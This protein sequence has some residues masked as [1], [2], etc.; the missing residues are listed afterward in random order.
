[1]NPQKSAL[2]M[3]EFQQEWLDPSV[4]KLDK[5][6]QDRAQFSA[7]QRSAKA[8]LEAARSRAV[9]VIHVP[10]LFQ[11]GYPEI[12]GGLRGGLFRAIPQAGTWIGEGRP[13]APGFEPFEGEF[14]VEGRV[15]A[16]AFA[17]SNLELYLRAQGVT[18]L[19]LC[20][21][22]LHVCVESTLRHGHVLGFDV[23]VLEDA[24]S[25]FTPEQ[26]KHVL[27]EVIHHYGHAVNVETFEHSLEGTALI[28]H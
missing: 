24:C 4:G 21:Y 23:T 17:H 15:G 5:L 28:A 9:R 27:E 1:M 13:F 26:R 10:C 19:Y 11:Q 22:A 18:D 16:S 8:A 7:S 12:A 6:M 14:V 2:V 3:I 20:G 25:A